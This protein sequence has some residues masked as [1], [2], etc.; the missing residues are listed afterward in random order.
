MYRPSPRELQLDDG[1]TDLALFEEEREGRL[2]LSNSHQER[3]RSWMAV[4]RELHTPRKF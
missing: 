4:R 1:S 3:G 2:E